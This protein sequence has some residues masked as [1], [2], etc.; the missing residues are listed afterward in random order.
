MNNH[1]KSPIIDIGR[2]AGKPIDQLPVS[3]LRWLIMQDFPKEWVDAAKKKVE[4]S[5]FHNDHMGVSRH[6]L[7]M[8]SMRH[9]DKWIDWLAKPESSP[10]GIASFVAKMAQEAWE[11][12][13]DIS[14]HRHQDDGITKEFRGI[15]FVFQVSSNFP[16][17][18]EVITC[19]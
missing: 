9:L 14:K 13:K 10:I 16:E 19:M 7:D 4:A 5:Q 2:Y 15:K 18:K 6:A 17:Y 8:F 1:P 12:G 11:N 3:Y